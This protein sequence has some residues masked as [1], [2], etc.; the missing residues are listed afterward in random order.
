[1]STER[2]AARGAPTSPPAPLA[3]AT[4]LG[5]LGP[6]AL[7]ALGI[8]LFALLE[9]GPRLAFPIAA[10]GLLAAEALG[11]VAV[12][13]LAIVV[14]ASLRSRLSSRGAAA[15]GGFAIVGF[16]FVATWAAFSLLKLRDSGAHLTWIDL[17][18]LASSLRQVAAEGTA[19][20][21]RALVLAALFPIVGA[22]LAALSSG[23]LAKLRCRI[24]ARRWAAISGGAAAAL[25]LAI[26]LSPGVR[27]ALFVVD[28][29]TSFVW[30]SLDEDESTAGEGGRDAG[31]A[32]IAPYVAPRDF[33]RANVVVLMLE[34]VP[35]K[36]LFGPDARRE[37]TPNL[38]AL[39]AESTVFHRAYATS[40]HSDYA[41]TSILASLHPRKFEHHDFFD[42]LSYPRTLPWDLFGPLG[43]RTAVFS[44]QN[45]RWG[46]M[47][48]FLRTPA[49]ATFRHAPDWPDAPRR[50]EGAEAKVFEATPVDAFLSWV[51]ADPSAPFVAYLNFQ[52][53]HYPY[54]VP[55]GEPEPYQPSRIDFPTSFLGY[56]LAKRP[57]MENR[58]HNALAYV[59]RQAGRLVDG[60]R[61]EGRFEETVLLV[62]SDHGEAF[63]EHGLPTHG[64]ALHEEQVRTAMFVRLPG[65][66]AAAID[67]PVSVLDALPAIVRFL[68]LP[69]HGNHQGRG[70]VLDP[71]YRRGG[72]Q[73]RPFLFTIQGMTIEDGLLLGDAK[74]IVNRHWR[75]RSLYELALDPDERRNLLTEDPERALA[76]EHRLDALLASQLSYYRERGWERSRYPRPLP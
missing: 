76:L 17:R 39:A 47:Q 13:A 2:G 66:A 18:F 16:G 59:D 41:Q 56:P 1:M 6:P 46:N 44:S 12:G 55:E 75:K 22:L 8:S 32:P 24:A 45:E 14:R 70:D 36:R 4:D 21:R 35:W 10:A 28:P 54:V 74:L 42:D 37:S 40:T 30:R 23:L 3:P 64:T 52:A 20:E 33:R 9:L 38:L 51:A 72:G 25:A 19:E 7:W 62:V 58:F 67:E 63:Y 26:A 73:G 53:T 27:A 50:G 57:V 65:R 71:P 68:G 48:A 34:S 61:R 43:Y 31:G 29:V 5:P 15:W 69:E 11:A 49:L 60:L